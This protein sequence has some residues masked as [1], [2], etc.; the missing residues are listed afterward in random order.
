MPRILSGGPGAGSLS[1]IGNTE[2]GGLRGVRCQ[3]PNQYQL[4]APNRRQRKNHTSKLH[5]LALLLP[6]AL[7]TGTKKLT[8]VWGWR[9]RRQVWEAD[10]KILQSLVLG[11]R[12]GPFWRQHQAGHGPA[13]SGPFCG[14]T[15][16]SLGDPFLQRGQGQLGGENGQGA[17]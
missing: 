1:E 2:T 4:L 10:L 12:H 11:P 16:R 7:K 14:P 6:V 9:E 8:K 13:L 5:E 15:T 3:R 17:G